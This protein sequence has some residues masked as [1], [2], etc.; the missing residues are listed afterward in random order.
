V[1]LKLLNQ[2]AQRAAALVGQK[3]ESQIFVQLIFTFFKD[4]I[5]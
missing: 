4:T 2:A 5:I 3:G 1:S